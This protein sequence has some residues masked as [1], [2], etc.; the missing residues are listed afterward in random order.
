MLPWTW[1]VLSVVL[2]VFLFITM[3]NYGSM[4]KRGPASESS[5]GVQKKSGVGITCR[6]QPELY[7]HH[8]NQQYAPQSLWHGSQSHGHG[9]FTMGEPPDHDQC[10]STT[11]DIIIEDVN[12]PITEEDSEDTWN[13]PE[14][15]PPGTEPGMSIHQKSTPSC[16]LNKFISSHFHIVIATI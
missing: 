6:S 14:E 15:D 7:K 16:R 10:P 1:V 11:A 4:R 8:G 5:F 3:M 2:S 9:P 13:T 12:L